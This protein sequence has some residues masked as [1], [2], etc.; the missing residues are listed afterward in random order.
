M[1]DNSIAAAM[2]SASQGMNAQ[3][4]RLR[5]VSE[6]LSNADT[7][8]YRRKLVSFQNE[9]DAKTGTERLAVGDV[10]LDQ[11]L[12]ERL[13]D[14]AHPLADE[15]GYVLMS[16]VDMMI[17]LSD[18]REASRSYEANL[19]TFQQARKMYGGLLDLIRR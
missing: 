19:T 2:A 8:G 1:T 4:F 11:S 17:E 9:Y 16:N 15:Q 13:F 7:H 14:P 6:N 18:A 5:I 12:G 3:A 10:S